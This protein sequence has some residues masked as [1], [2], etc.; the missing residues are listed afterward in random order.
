[1][2]LATSFLA[3]AIA[4]AS[5][6]P[7]SAASITDDSAFAMLT[8][9]DDGRD[10]TVLPGTPVVADAG[11][12]LDDVMLNGWVDALDGSASFSLSVAYDG[13]EAVFGSSS[14]YQFD[15]AETLSFLFDLDDSTFFGTNQVLATLWIGGLAGDLFAFDVDLFETATLTIAS[16]IAP[17]P[18][19]LPAT[20]PL[21]VG[22]FGG[23]AL[24][25]RR[26]RA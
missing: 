1:M 4:V 18:I 22:A 10:L 23:S 21:L 9:F 17:A 6:L 12:A 8:V 16:A 3:A 25:L 11:F 14:A 2:K 24:L 13:T 19:P 15:G 20:L 7:A 5:L 26:R